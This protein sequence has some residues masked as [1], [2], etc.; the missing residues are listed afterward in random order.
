MQKHPVRILLPFVNLHDQEAFEHGYIILLDDNLIISTFWVKQALNFVKNSETD[1]VL[2]WETT[3][4]FADI[5][6]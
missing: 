3:S 1:L 5:K 4:A 2:S 6:Q